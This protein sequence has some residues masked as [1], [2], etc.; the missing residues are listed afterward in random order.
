LDLREYARVALEVVQLF[1]NGI[2]HD[3]GD[4]FDAIEEVL[5]NLEYDP[6]ERLTDLFFELYHRDGAGL[7]R[8]RLHAYIF[9]NRDEFIAPNGA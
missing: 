1:R 7:F 8:E 6:F 2:P 9:A 4:R 5:A 3:P